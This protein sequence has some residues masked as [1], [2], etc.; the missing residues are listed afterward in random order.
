MKETLRE[1]R[2][3]EEILGQVEH[4]IPAKHQKPEMAEALRDLLDHYGLLI[5]KGECLPDYL[6]DEV[7]IA[8]IVLNN[9]NADSW[10]VRAQK[11]RYGYK[12]RVVDEFD[13]TY[14]IWPSRSQ[15]PL[16]FDVMVKLIDSIRDVSNPGEGITNPYRDYNLHLMDNPEEYL[17]F[18]IVFSRFYPD[19]TMWYHEE[20]QE[21]LDTIKAQPPKQE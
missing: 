10:S 21:W 15:T 3:E 11:A 9:N 4:E 8:R 14:K 12:F 18:V 16:P 1:L 17:D 7:E 20:A 2:R 19:L 13:N 5:N 6:E